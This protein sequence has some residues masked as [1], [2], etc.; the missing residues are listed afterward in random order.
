MES[1]KE[2]T[3]PDGIFLI[4]GLQIIGFLRKLLGS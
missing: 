2:K 1:Q 4:L 3:G